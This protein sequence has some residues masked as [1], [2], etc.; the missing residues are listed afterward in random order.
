MAPE[1]ALAEVAALP[2]GSWVLDPMVGSGTVV[3]VA[4]N[5][6]HR[7]IG[8]D[9]DPLAVLMAKVWTTPIEADRLRQQARALVETIRAQPVATV[10]LPWID[11][12]AETAAYVTYWFAR[13]QRDDL[14]R[15]SAALQGIAGPV[16]DAL[17]LGL[18]RIVVTKDHGA[19]LARDVSHSRPHRTRT[20]NDFPV[21][22]EFPR[23]VARL[24]QQLKDQPPPGQATVES[25]DARHLTAVETGSIDSVITSPPYLNAIDYLRGHRLALVWLGYRLSDLRALRSDSVGAERGPSASAALDLAAE[26][27]AP[28]EPL[29]RL[30]ARQRRMVDRYVLDVDAVLGEIYR[31]LRPG[32]TA[33]VVIGNSC[34]RG[35]FIRN[36]RLLVNAAERIGFTLSKESER[37]LPPNRRYLPPPRVLTTSDLEKRMRTET[38]LTFIR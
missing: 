16:G 2:P 19:S 10:R 14:R 24:A 36:A 15:L 33:V 31:V 18:S 1:I 32:A 20:T 6:G 38:V 7:A 5:R 22:D 29:D 26:L 8:F 12:D 27:T 34:V 17:R 23:A 21:L 35:V 13:E 11:D 9:L 37:V 28:L 30:P 3:R 25:G 4:A